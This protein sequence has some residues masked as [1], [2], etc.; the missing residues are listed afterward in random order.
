[1]INLIQRR[2]IIVPCLITIASSQSFVRVYVEEREF[3]IRKLDRARNRGLQQSAPEQQQP[4]NRCFQKRSASPGPRIGMLQ[5]TAPEE[6]AMQSVVTAKLL[7]SKA[8]GS[9]NSVIEIFI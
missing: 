8:T 1:M 9:V 4:G 2:E 5:R 3:A 7:V 6:C